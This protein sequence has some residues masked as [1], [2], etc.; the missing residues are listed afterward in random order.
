MNEAVFVDSGAWIAL[1]FR[2]DS[3][4]AKTVDYL[5]AA[6]QQQRSLVTTSAVLLEVVDG[7]SGHGL[8]YLSQGF[9]RRI[10]SLS[11]CEVVPMDAALFERGWDFFDARADKAWSLTDC[12]SFVVMQQRGLTDALAY[13]QHF[14]QAGFRALL[15]E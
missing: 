10:Q 4:H 14:A 15:R 2:P 9:R 12:I 5:V 8:R 1:L 6:Q 3:L 7:L 11:F 13:D